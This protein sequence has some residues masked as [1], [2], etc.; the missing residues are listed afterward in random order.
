MG[1]HPPRPVRLQ[2]RERPLP[3]HPDPPQRRQQGV[4]R[5]GVGQG[6]ILHILCAIPI[7]IGL[8]RQWAYLENYCTG[9]A[10]WLPNLLTFDIAAF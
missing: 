10:G 3:L 8:R 7:L 9:A 5:E 4:H 1:R 2:P 6:G